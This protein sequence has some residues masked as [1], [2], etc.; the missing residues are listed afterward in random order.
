MRIGLVAVD[1]G[2]KFPNLALG[3]LSAWHKAQGDSVEWADPM[4]G[5]YDR[6]YMSK[7]FIFTPPPIQKYMIVRLLKEELVIR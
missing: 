4:F 6:V 2:K 1:G 3:K 7:I 5:K